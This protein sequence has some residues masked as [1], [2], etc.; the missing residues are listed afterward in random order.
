MTTKLEQIKLNI[1]EFY[2]TD[3][4]EQHKKEGQPYYNHMTMKDEEPLA[5]AISLSRAVRTTDSVEVIV[6]AHTEGEAIDIVTHHQE[7]ETLEE[8]QGGEYPERDGWDDEYEE[9]EQVTS[10]RHEY[11]QDRDMY[12]DRIEAFKNIDKCKE[13]NPH[14]H[15]SKSE[16]L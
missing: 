6:Y 13:L 1:G 12:K 4:F 9:W 10:P 8:L 11:F 16:A 3:N 7:Y 5:W 15:N 14:L 2:Q